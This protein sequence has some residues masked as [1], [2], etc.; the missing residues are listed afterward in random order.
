MTTPR[1]L[2]ARLAACLAAASVALAGCAAADSGSPGSGALPVVASFYPL[3]FVAEQIGGAHVRVTNL[4]KAGRRAARPRA[5][6]EGRRPQVGKATLVVYRDGLPAGRRRG[7]RRR[8]TGPRPR[9]GPGRE[10]GPDVH[11][12]RGRGPA[13]GRGPGAPTRTSGSTRCATPPSPRPSPTGWRTRRP[14]AP[15]PTTPPT[16]RRSRHELAALDAEFRRGLAHCASTSTRHQPRRLRLPRPPL[17]PAARWASPA[18][19]PRP[20]P[21]AATLAA[22]RDLVEEHRRQHDLL[23]DAGQPRD[24]R[25]G[26]P[27]DG[28]EGRDPRPDRGP[29]QR[30]R[31]AGLLRGH[32]LQPRGPARRTGLLVTGRAGGAPTPVLLVAL[33]R[34]RLRRASRSCPTSTSTCSPARSWRCSG[35]TGRASRRWCAG[36]SG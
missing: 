11:A 33:G 18:S 20:S 2:T 9:R 6:A 5:D 31:R 26:G 30:L 3:Q 15:R 7:R 27:G 19:P 34:V 14:G 24:R 8:G 29:D 17:R 1:P 21:S 12:G 13:P 22:R 23:R 4:T 32:A 35:P 10:A 25:D 28:R 36:C 16:R